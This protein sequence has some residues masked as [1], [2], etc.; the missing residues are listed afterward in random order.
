MIEIRGLLLARVV[1]GGLLMANET[2][3]DRPEPTDEVGSEGGSPGDVELDRKT[4]TNGRESTSSVVP[5][6]VET[7]ERDR[8]K[9]RD[10]RPS[11]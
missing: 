7:E 11:P 5:H 10:D 8:N 4:V 1:A 9:T 6:D 2:K 3:R